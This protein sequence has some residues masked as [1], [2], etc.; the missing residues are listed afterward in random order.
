MQRLLIML[1]VIV[2]QVVQD[3]STDYVAQAHS[4]LKS[5]KPLIVGVHMYPTIPD[6]CIGCKVSEFPKA[7]HGDVVVVIP[8][9]NKLWRV[10]CKPEEAVAVQKS[11]SIPDAL[12]EVNA[13]RTA[14]GLRPF[15]RDE[16]LTQAAQQAAAF[17]A[18]RRMFGHTSNDFSFVPSGC[19]ATAAGCAAWPPSLGWGACCTYDNHTYAGASYSYGSDG[20]RYMHLFVR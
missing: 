8:F 19:S 15:I 1:S 5:G 13:T 11:W 3:M 10:G 6:G 4:A 7:E 18:S 14:R 2:G 20:L 12:D 9:D 16:G 17:R